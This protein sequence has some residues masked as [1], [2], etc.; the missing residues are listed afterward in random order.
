MLSPF[1]PRQNLIINTGFLVLFSENYSIQL[2]DKLCS[3]RVL[4]LTM[5]SIYVVFFICKLLFIPS[6]KLCKPFRF[7]NNFVFTFI[8]GLEF[9]IVD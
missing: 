6:C 8:L 4:T 3:I 7:F 9:I 1:P 5:T 2:I